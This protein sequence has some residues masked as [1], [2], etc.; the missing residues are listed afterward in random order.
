MIKLPKVFHAAHHEL[1]HKQAGFSLR[2]AQG[3]WLA[4]L[5]VVTLIIVGGAGYSMYIFGNID[6]AGDVVI[7]DAIPTTTYKKSIVDDVLK[8]YRERA[9]YF[10]DGNTVTV[11]PPAVVKTATATPAAVPVAAPGKIEVQ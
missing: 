1:H 3:V 8:R 11:A 2:T 6:H 9:K 10:K 4:T 7:T 5:S